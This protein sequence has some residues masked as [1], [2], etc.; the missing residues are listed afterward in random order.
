[1]SKARH[2]GL[3]RNWRLGKLAADYKAHKINKKSSGYLK[4]PTMRRRKVKAKKRVIRCKHEYE[5][6]DVEKRWI[7]TQEIYFCA[8]CN[9]RKVK[10]IQLNIC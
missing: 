8:K 3:G 9:K 7:W 2:F 4:E 10:C 6:A 5:F 1:M